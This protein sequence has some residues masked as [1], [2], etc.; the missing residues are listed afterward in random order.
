MTSADIANYLDACE[1]TYTL[2]G[3]PAQPITGFSS[4]ASLQNGH[5]CWVRDNS[6][7]VAD[8]LARYTG[9]TVVCRAAGSEIFSQDHTYFHTNDPRRAF[10]MVL[11]HFFAEAKPI[12]TIASTAVVETSAIGT[13]CTI[14]HNCYIAK[15]VTIGNNVTIEHN[16]VIQC[17]CSIGDG[18][19]IHSGVIIGGAGYGFYRDSDGIL[20]HAP[21]FGG[22]RIGKNVEILAN[23][24]IDRGTLDDTTIDD[25]V[26][27]GNLCIIGHNSHVEES[28]EVVGLNALLGGVVMEKN[29]YTAPGTVVRGYCR[30]GQGALAGLGSVVLHDV[31]PN[32]TVA[33]VPAKVIRQRKDTDSQ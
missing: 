22:V 13:G 3:S 19:T 18:T 31:P 2:A 12:D 8:I 30:I 24:C 17:K 14:G 9:L 4:L 27:I 15:N 21:H 23:T 29:S 6:S 28:A 20:H 32:T 25:N 7:A 10:F 33:G 11:D 16:V 1:E 5:L 26:K